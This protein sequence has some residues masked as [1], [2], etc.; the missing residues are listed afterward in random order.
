MDKTLV[1]DKIKEYYQFKSNSEFARFLGINS[2]NIRNWYA[3]NNYNANLLIEK[4]PE[5]N[6]EYIITGDGPL[7]KDGNKLLALP[8]EGVPYYGINVTASI[9]ESFNDIP[10]M[11]SYKINIPYLNDCTAA[12]PVY[13][14]SMLPTYCP[15][16]TVVVKEVKNKESMLWGEVYLIITNS[17]CDNLRT[18]KKVYISDDRKNFILRATNPDYA[19]DTI[20]PCDDVLKLFLVKGKISRT[21][22]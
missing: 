8:K 16:D 14:D 6:P 21:Q 20:V 9:T 3:R 10:E 12:F 17:N 22:L 1:L 2:Q 15:G 13:G 5:V 18:I 7:L 19:G 11:P 4:C